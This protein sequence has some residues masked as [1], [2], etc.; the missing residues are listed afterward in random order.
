[1]ETTF[2]CPVC[3]APQ[4]RWSA[5]FRAG[6]RG[7]YRCPACHSYLQVGGRV[8]SAAVAALVA[9]AFWVLNLTVPLYFDNKLYW[10]GFQVVTVLLVFFGLLARL[11]RVER[12]QPMRRF[13]P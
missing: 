4:G 1:M 12:R 9:L 10:I 11:L 13:M 6:A 7:F 5:F 3:T 8:I 2:S